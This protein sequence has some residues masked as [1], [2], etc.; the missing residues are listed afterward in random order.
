MRHDGKCYVVVGGNVG[1]E[2]VPCKQHSLRS[3]LSAQVSARWSFDMRH[4][5][6]IDGTLMGS[7][8]RST[9]GTNLTGSRRCTEE[10]VDKEHRLGRL[11]ITWEIF[12]WTIDG[13]Y[14]LVRSEI[15]LQQVDALNLRNTSSIEPSFL[16]VRRSMTFLP[17]H[18]SIILCHSHFRIWAILHSS[19]IEFRRAADVRCHMRRAEETPRRSGAVW[20]SQGTRLVQYATRDNHRRGL[21][22]LLL[23]IQQIT[24]FWF[25][26]QRSI[27]TITMSLSRSVAYA[28]T[29]R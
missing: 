16:L 20:T 28:Q 24:R 13:C 22:S 6:A 15:Y 1:I 8:L 29:K 14:I 9:L 27:R 23:Y 21:W 4:R 17:Y 11:Y 7:I 12:T 26:G 5:A 18:T 3:Y 19:Y 25:P 10:A 2:E